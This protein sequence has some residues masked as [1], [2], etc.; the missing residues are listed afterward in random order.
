MFARM[1]R[2][3]ALPA[4]VSLA[5]SAALASPALTRLPAEF[6][7][8]DIYLQVRV[9]DAAPLWMKLDVAESRSILSPSAAKALGLADPSQGV[10]LRAGAIAFSN[11]AFQTAST[12]TCAAPVSILGEDFLGDRVLMIKPALKEVWI[13]EPVN[14]GQPAPANA[15]VR[16]IAFRP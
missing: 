12:C 9:N 11:V 15:N 2:L 16:T 7:G 5:A 4:L 14:P 3:L 10:T 6:R 8:S 1:L 13:S